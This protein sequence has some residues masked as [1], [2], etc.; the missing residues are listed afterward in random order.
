MSTPGFTAE[1]C[2]EQST[3][4]YGAAQNEPEATMSV[5][6]AQSTKYWVGLLKQREGP[7]YYFPPDYCPPGMRPTLVKTGGE[8]ICLRWSDPFCI[9]R[10]TAFEKCWPPRCVQEVTSNVVYSWECQ[11]PTFTAL[12]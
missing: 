2:L 11:L 5:H 3:R 1:S 10:G 7:Y 9:N 12:T 4:R 6:P 8:T